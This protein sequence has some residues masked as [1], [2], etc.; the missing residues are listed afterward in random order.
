MRQVYDAH[1]NQ[2]NITLQ[3]GRMVIQ[4]LSKQELLEFCTHQLFVRA[5]PRP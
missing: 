5:E 4:D 3:V 1:V 2:P